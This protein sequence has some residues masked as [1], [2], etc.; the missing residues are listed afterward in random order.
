[1]SKERKELYSI[2]NDSAPIPNNLSHRASGQIRHT[3]RVYQFT[4]FEIAL[5]AQNAFKFGK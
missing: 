5:R 1:M 3:D 4:E 2:P